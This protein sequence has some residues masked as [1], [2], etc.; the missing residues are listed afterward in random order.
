VQLTG[1]CY[2]LTSHNFSGWSQVS[3]VFTATSTSEVLSFLA[4][5]NRPVPPF[6]MI[7]DVSLLSG[8]PEPATWGLMLLGF[9][10]LGGAAYV[11]R[12]RAAALA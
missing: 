3:D 5:G 12:R 10:G 7:S 8:V 4:A 9:G 2:Y 6:A 11:R 1:D